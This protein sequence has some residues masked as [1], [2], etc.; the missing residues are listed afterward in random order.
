V[1]AHVRGINVDIDKH[2][3]IGAADPAST[4][5]SK[6]KTWTTPLC[7]ERDLP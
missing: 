1:C 6:R 4:R 7:A 3:D 2:V 5:T